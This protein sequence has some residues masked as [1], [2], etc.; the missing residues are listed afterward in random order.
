MKTIPTYLI[1]RILKKLKFLLLSYTVCAKRK[2][3][4][5][6]GYPIEYYFFFIHTTYKNTSFSNLFILGESVTTKR[7]K[8][9]SRSINYKGKCKNHIINHT[10]IAGNWNRCSV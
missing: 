4:R 7:N 10:R 8:I 1:Y 6:N 2:S 5:N 3:T 9:K